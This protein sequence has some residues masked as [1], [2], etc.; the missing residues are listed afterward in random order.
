MS[1]EELDG[2]IS[3]VQDGTYTL[4]DAVET[5]YSSKKKKTNRTITRT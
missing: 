3:Q 1:D 2:I 5:N 4:G